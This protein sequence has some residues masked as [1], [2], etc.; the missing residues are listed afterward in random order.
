MSYSIDDV[1]ISLQRQGR[2]SKKLGLKFDYSKSLTES[3]RKM[4]NYYRHKLEEFGILK[5][6]H[7]DAGSLLFNEVMID[8]IYSAPF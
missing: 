4:K 2:S 6:P 5:Y 7:S 3:H 8:F 1:E